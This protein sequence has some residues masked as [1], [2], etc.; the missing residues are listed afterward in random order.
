MIHSIYKKNECRR[1]DKLEKWLLF[2]EVIT[3]V[4]SSIAV[5]G[6]LTSFQKPWNHPGPATARLDLIQ[7]EIRN[8]KVTAPRNYECAQS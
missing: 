7:V 3:Y 2:S 8:I 6:S 5:V 4:H 1:F